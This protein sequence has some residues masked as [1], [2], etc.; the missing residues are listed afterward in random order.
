MEIIK[1][2][3]LTKTYGNLTAVNNISFSVNK[4]EL[5]GFL[6]VNGAGKS[7]TIN[8]LSTLIRPDNGSADLCGFR[9]GGQNSEIRRRIGIVSQN[10]CLDNLMTVRENLLCRGILH[11]A[12]I[13]RGDFA[14]IGV[15]IIPA[16]SADDAAHR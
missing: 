13:Q 4:G 16:T 15:I 7:T 2:N 11:G 1:I 3:G 8:M 12:D 9:L 10:N 6:G 14:P 5:L